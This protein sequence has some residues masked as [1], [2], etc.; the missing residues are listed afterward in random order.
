[1][2]RASLL[3]IRGVSFLVC[4]P[5][6][7]GPAALVGSVIGCRCG[8][9]ASLGA[10]TSSIRPTTAMIF[11]RPSSVRAH[12]PRRHDD[13]YGRFA[14]M[15][16]ALRRAESDP[17]WSASKW[18]KCASRGRFH[19]IGRRRSRPARRKIS[20]LLTYDFGQANV[21]SSTQADSAATKKEQKVAAL[22]S[23]MRKSMNPN[24]ALWEKGD[25]TPIAA[26]MHEGGEALIRRW[27]LERLQSLESRMRRQHNGHTSGATSENQRAYTP[28]RRRRAPQISAICTR[29]GRSP[30]P[31]FYPFASGGLGWNLPASVGIALAERDSGRNRPLITV[32]GDGSF[33]YSVQSIWSA[34]QLHLPMLILV[35]RNEEY[36]ILKSFAVLE[37]APGVPGLDLPGIDIVS[38]ARGYGC[39]AARLDDIGAIKKAAAKAWVKQKPTVLEIP[40]SAEVPPLI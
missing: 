40:I 5:T 17:R 29:H 37:E 35:L 26:R 25:F 39:D 21:G 31:T 33:Q 12:T 3:A 9:S 28:L 23:A 32:I 36:C 8:C 6:M 16:M 7:S 34:A 30:S 20:A 15:G 18:K 19:P 22:Q 11:Q 1:M 4:S 38:V 10:I 2:T 24:K 27:N 14:H 13:G